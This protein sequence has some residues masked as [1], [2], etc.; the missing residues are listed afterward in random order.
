MVLATEKW[1][2]WLVFGLGG[3]FGN[4]AFAW[5]WRYSCAVQ[6]Y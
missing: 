1:L 3:E 6:K 5:R 2:F 4:G